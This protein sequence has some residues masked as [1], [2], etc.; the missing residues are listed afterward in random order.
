MWDMKGRPGEM[1]TYEQLIQGIS[2][3]KSFMYLQYTAQ[4]KLIRLLG[5]NDFVLK[6]IFCGGRIKC[7]GM[8][9]QFTKYYSN[10]LNDQN[11]FAN[12]N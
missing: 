4:D 6:M 3:E 2:R 5:F 10:D 11:E 9:M 7:M 8:R 1:L 12:N